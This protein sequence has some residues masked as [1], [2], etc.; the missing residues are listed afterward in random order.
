MTN[1]INQFFFI[2]L[3]FAYSI[4]NIKLF[5]T[6]NL[7]ENYKKNKKIKLD[8]NSGQSEEE[9]VKGQGPNSI[10]FSQLWQ[11]IITREK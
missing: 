8:T 9:K 1:L 3:F 7:L 2:P 11:G 10:R 6:E 4:G 5:V